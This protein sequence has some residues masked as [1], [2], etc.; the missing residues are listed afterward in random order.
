[1]LKLIIG[2]RAYSSWAMRGWLALKA[3]ELEFE[4]IPFP[5]TRDYVIRI[6][7]RPLEEWAL[8]SGRSLPGTALAFLAPRSLGS[9]WAGRADPPSTPA[10]PAAGRQWPAHEGAR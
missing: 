8:Q 7:G 6:T 3:S 9:A 2:N 5:E 10:L 1:M 4:D